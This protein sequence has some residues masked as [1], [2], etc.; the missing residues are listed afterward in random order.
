MTVNDEMGEVMRTDGG[1]GGGEVKTISACTQR[2]AVFSNR[3]Q[4]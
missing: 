4:H 1:E 2:I 3:K